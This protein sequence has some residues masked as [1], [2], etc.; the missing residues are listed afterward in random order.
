MLVTRHPRHVAN[1]L[2]TEHRVVDVERDH[3]QVVGAV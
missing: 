3:R 1:T 2:E